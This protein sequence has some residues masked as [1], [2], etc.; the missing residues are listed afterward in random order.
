MIQLRIFDYELR[1]EENDERNQFCF[2]VYSL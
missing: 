2:I 1:I